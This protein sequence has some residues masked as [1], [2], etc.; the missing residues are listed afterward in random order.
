MRQ[1]RRCGG[2]GSPSPRALVVVG[3]VVTFLVL[4]SQGND[5]GGDQAHYLIAAQ[6]LA[7][8]SLH[9]GPWYQRDFLAHDVY[10][11]PAGATVSNLH[12]VQ[13]YPGPHG[14]VFA[15]GLGLPLLLAP[16]VAVGNV[17]LGL[18][19][20]FSVVALGAVCIHQ[21]GSRL[22][23]LERPG[24]IVFALASGRAGAVGRLDP[25]LPRPR[26]RRAPGGGVGRGGARR[27]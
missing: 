6:T 17:P 14:S 13:T 8:G 9:P 4:R 2:G 10:N 11:W 18:L 3:Q 7:H 20:L 26:Q 21:R 24:R 5:L 27:A 25:G 23:R 15:H 1:R 12:I 22:A 19:G 16:F